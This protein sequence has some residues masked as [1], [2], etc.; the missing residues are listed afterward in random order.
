MNDL[1]IANWNN[2]VNKTDIVYF[3]GDWG[4]GRGSRPSSHWKK[5]LNGEILSIK[6]SHDKR[7]REYR[8]LKSK[9]H[10]FLLIH[11][12]NNALRWNGWIMHGHIHNNKMDKYPFINGYRKTINVSIE[13][14][15]YKPIN[16]DSIEALKIDSIK[17]MRTSSSTP[18]RW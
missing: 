13:L 16:L 5:R 3:L 4:F 2:T 9:E 10:T 12:P 18:E 14:T 1:I 11:D 6:G 8:I 7:G 17:W 15:D